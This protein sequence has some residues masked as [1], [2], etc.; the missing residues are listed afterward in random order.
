MKIL[1]GYAD[2]EGTP[3]KKNNAS[4]LWNVA[5]VFKYL[6]HNDNEAKPEEIFNVAHLSLNKRADKKDVKDSLKTH[7]GAIE[8]IRKMYECDQVRVGFWGASHDMA[9]LSS[10]NMHDICPFVPIDLLSMARSLNKDNDEIKSYN[11]GKLC[12]HFGVRVD[13]E[14]KVHTGL[15]DVI[16]MIQLFPHLGMNDPISISNHLAI[17][18]DKHKL[19]TKPSTN[20]KLQNVK[21]VPRSVQRYGT[22]GHVKD[23]SV[24]SSVKASGGLQK[25]TTTAEI[26]RTAIDLARKLKL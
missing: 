6:I 26:A 19:K 11:I 5:I 15:G 25:C 7:F 17:G 14:H 12:E 9:V 16:R 20:S 24:K 23:K 18:A 13:E 2:T 1:L 3:H 8:F 22:T 21:A 10:Y 4:E